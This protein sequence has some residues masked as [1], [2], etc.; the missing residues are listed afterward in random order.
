MPAIETAAMV[1]VAGMARSY[2]TRDCHRSWFPRAVNGDLR[3]CAWTR[4][5]LTAA[6]VTVGRNQS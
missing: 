3:I 1:K 2:G 4:Q 6:G 5:W